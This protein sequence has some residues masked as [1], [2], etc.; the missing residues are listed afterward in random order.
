MP[1]PDN[2]FPQI[3]MG[4]YERH[5]SEISLLMSHFFIGYLRDL[6]HHFDGDLALV[7]VLG[8]IAH[9]NTA[10]HFSV[11]AGAHPDLTE[12]LTSDE[13]LR[14]KLP[15]CNAYSLAAATGMPRETIRRKIATLEKLG[16]VERAERKEVRITSKVGEHF[17]LDFN[18][19]LLSELFKTVDRI[20]GL[21]STST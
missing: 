19:S 18:L 10:D 8:E 21:L 3:P 7:I 15:T 11:Q 16:W 13:S 5:K 20:R 9:H 14:K 2:A 4:P 6:Y 17:Q 12:Q 1:S